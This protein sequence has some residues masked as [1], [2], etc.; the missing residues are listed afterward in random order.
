ME[1]SDLI[2]LECTD[3]R[4]QQAPVMEKDKVILLPILTFSVV[5]A[6]ANS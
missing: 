4:M 1:C 6:R 3:N 2:W 5:F